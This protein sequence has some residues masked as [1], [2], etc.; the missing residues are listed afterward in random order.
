MPKSQTPPP[1][2]QVVTLLDDER[3]MGPFFYV[4]ITTFNFFSGS[5]PVDFITARVQ[6]ILELNPW[7]QSRL[8]G[9]MGD[10]HFEYPATVPS[11][12]ADDTYVKCLTIPGFAQDQEYNKLVKSVKKH[13]VKLG[14]CYLNK[15]T[16]GDLFRILIVNGNSLVVSMSHM[17][18]DGNTYYEVL[19]MLDARPEFVPRA[20]SVERIDSFNA[21]R[22]DIFGASYYEWR[23]FTSLLSIKFYMET[24][25]GAARGNVYTIDKPQIE[26]I[27]QKYTTE[28]AYVSSNDVIASKLLSDCHLVWGSVST[29]SREYLGESGPQRDSTGTYTIG[30]IVTKDMSPSDVRK[31]IMSITNKTPLTEFPSKKETKE[32]QG[33]NISN[34]TKFQHFLRLPDGQEA[35]LHLPSHAT[36]IACN[37]AVIFK[38]KPEELSVLLL[39]TKK[40]SKHFKMGSLFTPTQNVVS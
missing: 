14:Y 6:Q 10:V 34:W 26:E 1:N 2:V 12:A 4:T 39:T 15:K 25:F 35:Q 28:D 5:V 24:V 23:S 21:M 9:K 17:L 13:L 7:L 11:T 40:S 33:M 38:A 19:K 3:K 29:N 32:G 18:G 22:Q 8:V 16:F 30:A 36:P 31:R 20:L 27:K 37:M